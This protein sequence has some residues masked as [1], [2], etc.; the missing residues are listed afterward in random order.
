MSSESRMFGKELLNKFISL[1]QF[2]GACTTSPLAGAAAV[3]ALSVDDLARLAGNE[4]SRRAQGNK[5]VEQVAKEL[6]NAG[7]A[8]AFP[9]YALN[10][11]GQPLLDNNGDPLP[12]GY[13]PPG[14]GSHFPG[15]DKAGTYCLEDITYSACIQCCEGIF[16]GS[17]ACK[18]DP[19][20]SFNLGAC[21]NACCGA[22][23]APSGFG[24]VC[25][26]M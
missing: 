14:S 6:Q 25:W 13:H 11:A 9:C 8:Q 24:Y 4:M 16:G 7:V 3:A 22:T 2:L 17:G 23:G 19:N 20:N 18:S 21:K 12:C 15:C 5:V 1:G 10:E 26:N